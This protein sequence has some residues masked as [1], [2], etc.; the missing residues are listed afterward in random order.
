MLADVTALCPVIATWNGYDVDSSLRIEGT[1]L[2]Y[3][4]YKTYSSFGARAYGTSTGTVRYHFI[5]GSTESKV[6]Y[7][8][9]GQWIPPIVDCI[10]SIATSLVGFVFVCPSF[11]LYIYIILRCIDGDDAM[12][13]HKGM[14]IDIKCH[15]MLQYSIVYAVPLDNLYNVNS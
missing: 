1:E 15:K 12:M 7:C 11:H 14:F 10:G 8:R 2:H 6:A 13:M 5:D 3:S 4:C 9:S